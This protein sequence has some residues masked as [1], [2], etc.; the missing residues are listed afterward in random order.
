MFVQIA[1][2]LIRSKVL[3]TLA[4]LG[5]GTGQPWVQMSLCHLLAL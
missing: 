1:W 4:S 2:S 5:F 3:V